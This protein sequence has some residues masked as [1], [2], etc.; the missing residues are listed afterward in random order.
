MRLLLVGPDQEENLSLRYLVSS[1]RAA[2]HQ[3]KIAAF[4]SASDAPSVLA[5]ASSAD[6]VGLSMCYQIRAAEF[7][8]LARSLKQANPQLRVLA[9]GHYA[10]CAA[11]DL[12]V[13]HPELDLIAVHECEPCFHLN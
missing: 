7:L 13:R 11:S 9:G 5:A 8:A 6:V 4:D 1:L 12:I 10:S 2:G 3:A